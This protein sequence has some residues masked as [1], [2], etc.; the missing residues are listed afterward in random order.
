MNIFNYLFRNLKKKL[1]ENLLLAKTY[2][3]VFTI[4]FNYLFKEKKLLF[5]KITNLPLG[6]KKVVLLER[7]LEFH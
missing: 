3:L 5:F 4:V 7:T 1:L 6:K 2:F